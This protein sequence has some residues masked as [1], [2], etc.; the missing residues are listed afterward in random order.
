MTALLLLALLAANDFTRVEEK[1]GVL[2]EAREVPGSSFVEYR[3]TAVTTGDA[4]E[5]CTKA[6][7]TGE[8][9]RDEPH[10]AARTLLSEKSDERLTW[11][12]IEAPLISPRDIIVRR[13]R[14]W[15]GGGGCRVE[16]HADPTA[17]PPVKSGTVR[18]VVLN[19][20]FTF[21]PLGGGKV[22]VEHRV[23]TEPG[24]LIAPFV[25]EPARREAAVAWVKRL[26]RGK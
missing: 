11:D 22:R 26:V 21:T 20:S 2:L 5:L 18:I 8:M 14:T 17:G 7:G 3:V 9:D 24:G 16:F 1:D 4:S 10:L 15:L 25:V 12:R 23:H 6:W 13:T 19:G